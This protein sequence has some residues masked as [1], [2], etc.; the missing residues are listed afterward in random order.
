MTSVNQNRLHIA[1]VA[2]GAVSHNIEGFF[3]LDMLCP[4]INQ[5]CKVDRDKDVGWELIAL[6][7][8]LLEMWGCINIKWSDKNNVFDNNVLEQRVKHINGRQFDDS[9]R[10][11][12]EQG[13]DADK[14]ITSVPSSYVRLID[15][16]SDELKRTRN[17]GT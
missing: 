16:N 12:K 10:I 5:L 2:I 3:R 8:T 11:L 15:L 14:I 1:N 4:I 9:V 7:V 13:I 17:G 6:I